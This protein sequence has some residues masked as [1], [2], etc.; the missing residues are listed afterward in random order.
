MYGSVG[1]TTIN[2]IY[3]SYQ[4]KKQKR[5]P[6]FLQGKQCSKKNSFHQF[7]IGG[8]CKKLQE[9]KGT[10]TLKFIGDVTQNLAQ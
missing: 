2:L 3:Q 8:M 4:H 10:S 9:F 5:T 7:L 1:K 6:S